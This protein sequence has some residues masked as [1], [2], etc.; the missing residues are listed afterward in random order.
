MI[1]AG[2]PQEA[3]RCQIAGWLPR[4]TS[5][6]IRAMDAVVNIP[7]EVV[8]RFGGPDA[9]AR[10]V[11]ESCAA[12]AYRRGQW[13]IADVSRLPGVATWQEVEEFLRE[14]DVSEATSPP[15]PSAFGSA[16]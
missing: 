8:E 14:H 10:Q 3:F 1:D 2:N 16:R 13:T 9:V 7:D 4:R 11:L 6:V 5:A 12:E 15:A